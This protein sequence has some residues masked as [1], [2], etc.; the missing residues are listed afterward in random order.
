MSYN[1]NKEPSGGDAAKN[2]EFKEES[3]NQPDTRRL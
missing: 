2:S 3:Y 1:K